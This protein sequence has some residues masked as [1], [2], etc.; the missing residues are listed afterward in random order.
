MFGLVMLYLALPLGILQSMFVDLPEL[1]YVHFPYYNIYIM[2]A[3]QC[4]CQGGH[5]AEK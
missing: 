5:K 1:L 3:V 4:S 2:G